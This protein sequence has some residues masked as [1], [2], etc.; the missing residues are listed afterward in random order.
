MAI[1]LSQCIGSDQFEFLFDSKA[2]KKAD[3][4]DAGLINFLKLHL[5]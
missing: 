4:V 1:K 3:T 2:S 5:L